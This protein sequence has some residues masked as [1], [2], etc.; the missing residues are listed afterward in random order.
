MLVGAL[1]MVAWTSFCSVSLTVLLQS[2]DLSKCTLMT[3]AVELLEHLVAL[4]H[5][6]CVF[7]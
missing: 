3:Q 2:A 5:V 4:N 7:C 1:R 6:K